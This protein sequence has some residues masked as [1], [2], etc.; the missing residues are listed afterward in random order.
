MKLVNM[1]LKGAP[2]FPQFDRDT[3]DMTE[4]QMRALLACILG[5]ARQDGTEASRMML[6]R[7]M[8]AEKAW[9]ETGGD[10]ADL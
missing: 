10:N 2:E 4:G 1:G 8:I 5:V 7:L 9:I 3:S 6:G